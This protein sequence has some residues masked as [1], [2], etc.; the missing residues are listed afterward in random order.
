MYTWYVCCVVLLLIL[1]DWAEEANSKVKY[2]LLSEPRSPTK[3]MTMYEK[4]CT[5]NHAPSCYNLAVMYKNGDH[6]IQPNEAKFVQF[7]DKTNE[8]VQAYGGLGS[9]TKTN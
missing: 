8:L 2:P 6:G 5:Q 4:A 7:R 1:T 3:A 9:G